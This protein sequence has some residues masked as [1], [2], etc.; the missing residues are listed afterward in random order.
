MPEPEVTEDS[1]A[2]TLSSWDSQS[3]VEIALMLGIT[4]RDEELD[5]S[6]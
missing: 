5:P 3:E 2:D 1:T 6:F 4:V